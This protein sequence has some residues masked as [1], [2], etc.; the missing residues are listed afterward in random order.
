MQCLQF[1]NFNRRHTVTDRR[2]NRNRAE[3]KV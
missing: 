3:R 1:V 2:Q